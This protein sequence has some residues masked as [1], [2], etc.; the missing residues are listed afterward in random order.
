[1]AGRT[2]LGGQIGLQAFDIDFS[3]AVN[4]DSIFF[5]GDSH[6]GLIDLPDFLDMPIDHCK[7]EIHQQVGHGLFLEIMDLA[8]KVYEMLV[9]GSEQ[10]KADFISEFMEP[11]FQSGSEVSQLAFGHHDSLQGLVGH[12]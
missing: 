12:V 11:F 10:F 4:A 8:G 2:A 7:V 3:L 1:L 6:Q 5:V 9:V